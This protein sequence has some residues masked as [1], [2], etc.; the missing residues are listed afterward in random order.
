MP[1]GC[2]PCLGKSQG[3]CAFESIH[4]EKEIWITDGK[5]K[6]QRQGNQVDTGEKAIYERVRGLLKVDKLTVPPMREFLKDHTRLPHNGTKKELADR[7]VAHFL[8]S[9]QQVAVGPTKTASD[10]PTKTA[11]DSSSESDS[12]SDGIVTHSSSSR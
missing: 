2:K 12:D 5:R 11:S 3:S 1:C 8:S 10:R 7:I 6:A 4:Q 9:T